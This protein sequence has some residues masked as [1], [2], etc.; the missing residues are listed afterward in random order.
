M[1]IEKNLEHNDV[2]TRLHIV[3]D[4]SLSNRF[5]IRSWLVDSWDV[6]ILVKGLFLGVHF[7][8]RSKK[9]LARG[10][11]VLFGLFSMSCIALQL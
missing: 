6:T 7:L 10:T 11:K 4:N 9:K 5:N 1:N 2:I 8:D 3:D